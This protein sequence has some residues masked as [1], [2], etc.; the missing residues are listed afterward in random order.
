MTGERTKKI[1]WLLVVLALLLAITYCLA[2]CGKNGPAD[3][4]EE[5]HDTVVLVLGGLWG[6]QTQEIC[7][8]IRL[9]CPRA[10]VVQ[11]KGVNGYESDVES[12]LAPYAGKKYL[13]LV[14]HSFGGQRVLEESFARGPRLL[15]L[16]DPVLYEPLWG[17]SHALPPGAFSKFDPAASG[18]T[19]VMWYRRSDTVGPDG[20]EPP[21]GFIVRIAP[22]GHDS[23]PHDDDVIDAVV[24]A[25]GAL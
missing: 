7:D 21:P 23:V 17:Q 2:G 12:L 14:G 10:D 25:I 3:K 20:L 1:F 22:G 18:T 16:L 6:D 13:V 11:G 19:G 24:A 4:P 15:V 9:G 8:K 5:Q